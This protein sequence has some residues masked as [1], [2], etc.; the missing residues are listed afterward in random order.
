MPAL[1]AITPTRQAQFKDGRKLAFAETGDPAGKPVFFF[2]SLPGCRLYSHPDRALTASLGVRLIRL[3]RPGFGLSDRQPG[4]TLLHWPDDVKALAD[5]LR[6]DQFAVLGHAAGGPYAAACAYKLPRRV[7]KAAIVAGLPPL[8][9]PNELAQV[10]MPMQCLCGLVQKLPCL[11]KPAL[12]LLWRYSQRRR[13]PRDFVQTM[14]RSFPEPDRR[15]FQEQPALLEMLAANLEEL[16]ASGKVDG[17]VAELL[18][19]ARAWG[20]RFD[21]I[22]VPVSLWWG[23]EER[24][25]PVQTARKIASALPDCELH[26]IPNAGHYVIFSHWQAILTD[27]LA[28]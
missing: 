8:A 6:I 21:E 22:V 17:Y 24:A 2:H 20:F 5:L 16:Q 19:L 7:T 12:Q 23:E 10:S 3:D 27:L 11:L 14:L 25:I 9:A 13:D 28:A 15:L 1:A 4:R 18:I 26:V